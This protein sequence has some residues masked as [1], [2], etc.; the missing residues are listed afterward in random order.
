MKSSTVRTTKVIKTC[1]QMS[2][3]NCKRNFCLNPV[4][5]KKG[6]V[7][8]RLE[9]GKGL[10]VLII[11]RMKRIIMNCNLQ[12]EIRAKSVEYMAISFSYAHNKSL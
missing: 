10:L 8:I 1:F 6:L 12:T 7:E 9:K 2:E 5:L 3:Q 11:I 4:S